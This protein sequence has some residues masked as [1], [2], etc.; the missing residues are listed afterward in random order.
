MIYIGSG[1]Y[2]SLKI[3]WSDCSTSK[4]IIDCVDLNKYLSEHKAVYFMWVPRHLGI[5]GKEQANELV[6]VPK[7]FLLV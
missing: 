7:T 6:M 1:R 2:A 3:L 4:L 5:E